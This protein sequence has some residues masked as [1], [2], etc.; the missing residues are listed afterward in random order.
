MALVHDYVRRANFLTNSRLG[1][2]LNSSAFSWE[3]IYS[4][5]HKFTISKR[6]LVKFARLTLTRGA[7]ITVL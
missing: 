2:L 4:N 1:I 3:F 7:I 5:F 6:G